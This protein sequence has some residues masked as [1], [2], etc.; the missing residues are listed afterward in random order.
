MT[1]RDWFLGDPDAVIDSIRDLGFEQA[2]LI[3]LVSM[4][5]S[6]DPSFEQLA[7]ATS[8]SVMVEALKRFAQERGQQ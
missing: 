8:P 6:G 1:I 5:E 3:E 4:E 7:R 2:A